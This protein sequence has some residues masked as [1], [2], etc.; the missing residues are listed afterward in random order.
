MKVS[1][2]I[3]NCIIKFSIISIIAFVLG[4]ISVFCEAICN[5]DVSKFSYFV[6]GYLSC[7][8]FNWRWF[9][10]AEGKEKK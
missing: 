9:I 3:F 1:K 4:F 6:L 7:L 8:I 2:I 10:Y 5:L